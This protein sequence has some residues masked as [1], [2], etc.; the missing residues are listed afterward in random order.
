MRAAR[1]QA[2]NRTIEPPLAIDNFMKSPGKPRNRLTFQGYQTNGHGA[3]KRPKNLLYLRSIRNSLGNP[4]EHI[5]KVDLLFLEHLQTEAIHD[6][7][8]GQEG[9]VLEAVTECDE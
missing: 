9:A 2:A 7:M 1:P 4:H 6:E 3:S 5:F 8:I